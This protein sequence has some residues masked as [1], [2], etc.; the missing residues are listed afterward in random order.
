MNQ[1]ET[2]Y[3]AFRLR[4]QFCWVPLT[5]PQESAIVSKT[6]SERTAGFT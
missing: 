4:L 2:D 3:D 5:F 1:K 6:R